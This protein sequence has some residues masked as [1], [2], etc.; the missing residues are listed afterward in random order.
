MS[1]EKPISMGNLPE[2][3]RMHEREEWGKKQYDPKFIKEVEAYNDKQVKAWEKNVAKRLEE[4]KQREEDDDFTAAMKARIYQNP[5][6]LNSLK[7]PAAP[8]VE[9]IVNELSNKIYEFKLTPYLKNGITKKQVLLKFA[10]DILNGKTD[11]KEKDIIEQFKYIYEDVLY[12]DDFNGVNDYIYFRL[13][14][15]GYYESPHMSPK[16]KSNPPTRRIKSLPTRKRSKSNS[17]PRIKSLP[18]RRIKSNSPTRKG[19]KK[20]KKKTLK[21]KN[22]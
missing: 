13:I 7:Q 4:A 22:K 3:I 20:N 8:T 2:L 12:D 21:K 5:T 18:T 15:L 16:K 17:P 9:E 14:N 1:S 19:G 6:L 11:I 10:T